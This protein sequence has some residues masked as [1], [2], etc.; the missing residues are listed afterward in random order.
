MNIVEIIGIRNIIIYVIIINILGFFA[1]G[2][3]KYK[4]KK[5]KWRIPENTL[6]MFTIL[7]G[8][9]GTIAGIYAFRHKTKKLKFTIG[10]P[11]ILILEILL[12]LYFKFMI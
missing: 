1:M 5:G 12:I 7:G 3:D 10:M 8:G 11:L 2:I 4:A 6:F 9:I